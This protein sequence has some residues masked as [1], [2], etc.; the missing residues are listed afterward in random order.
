MAFNAASCSTRWQCHGVFDGD[1]V[2]VTDD[3]WA[4]AQLTGVKPATVGGVDIY[5]VPRLD[6]GYAGGFGGQGQ[7]LNS[8]TIIV[9]PGTNKIITAFPGSGLPSPK[10]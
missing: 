9:Q 2:A 10:P 8:V 1:A 6:S 3:A 7:N 4:M 5:V